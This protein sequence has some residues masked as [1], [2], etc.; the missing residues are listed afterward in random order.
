MVQEENLLKTVSSLYRESDNRILAKIV[1]VKE[2]I[3]V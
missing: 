1:T 3:T 2:K